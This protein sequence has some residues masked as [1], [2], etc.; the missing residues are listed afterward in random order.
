MKPTEI[1]L[2]NYNYHLPEERIAKYPLEDRTSAR[3]IVYKNGD[4]FHSRFRSL[5]QWLPPQT[6]FVFNNTRVIHARLIFRKETGARIEILCLEPANT[7]AAD[8]YY[9]PQKGETTWKCMIGN[10]K[11]WKNGSLTLS[12]DIGRKTITLKAT[13][14]TDLDSASLV[15][16]QWNTNHNF[17]EI[18]ELLGHTPIPPYLKRE[19]EEIDRQAYQTVYAE[20][21][22]AV[23]APTAG[24]HFDKNMLDELEN[25]GFSRSTVTLHVSAGT[26]R[27]IE[28]SVAEHPMHREFLLF[29]KQQIEA[30]LSRKIL[31]C[32]GTTSVRAVES[33]YWFGVMCMQENRPDFFI[34][35]LY[36]Y[37]SHKNLPSRDEA[38]ESVL[39]YMELE[40]VNTLTG[41]SEIFILPGY[42]FHSCDALV[43]NFHM[44][45][46][47]LILLIAA[48]CK[49]WKK[50]YQQALENNYRFLSYGD[51]CL[52]LK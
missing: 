26:F 3:L 50:V 31:L 39:K 34:P 32:I 40:R 19:D 1:N 30:L 24:L 5:F 46:S 13:K 18:L 21:A 51:A 49:D 12:R 36:P 41:L 52:F 43:T 23:A 8:P 35:R 22:G 27:P 37:A 47:T 11:K 33:L 29:S 14:L 20:I 44:P 2:E 15:K 25:K 17:Y 42:A 10:R 38:F 45:K 6:H 16:F 4:I 28:T 7:H 9:Q 48:F